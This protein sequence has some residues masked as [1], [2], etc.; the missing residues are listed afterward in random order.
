MVQTAMLL[1]QVQS[2][3]VKDGSGCHREPFAI[4]SFLTGCANVNSHAIVSVTV[5][6]LV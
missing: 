2:Q 3:V 1:L 5:F 4:G 6:S